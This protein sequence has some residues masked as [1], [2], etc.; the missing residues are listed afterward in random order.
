MGRAGHRLHLPSLAKVREAAPGLL[1]PAPIVAFDPFRPPVAAEGVVTV[2]SLEAAARRHPPARTVVHL[3]TPPHVRAAML[4]RLAG[5][6]YRT[7]IVEKP[8]AVDLIGLAA[9]ARI[10]RR[11]NL[12]L[13]VATHWLDSALTRRLRTAVTG[14]RHGNLRSIRVVQNKPRFAL[15]A[16]ARTHPTAF[17][18]EVPHALA[19]ALD[20][21][22]NARIADASSDDL[23]IGDRTIPR[24]GR[25]RLHLTHR[26]GV[27]T[28]IDSDLT[29]PVRER[30]IT[31]DFDDGLLIGHYPC[32]D[33][34]HT[35]Q[36]RAV[37]P[38]GETSWTVFDDDALP[39]FLHKT[40]ERY[41]APAP[42]PNDTLSLQ[43]DV[44]RLLTE[45]KRLCAGVPEVRGVG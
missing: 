27:R 29:S 39:A 20:L 26:S 2:G 1:A 38:G 11:W 18:V 8:L 4:D 21:A 45:A 15:G 35:A 28:E 44:V 42:A 32:S 14:G 41:A 13:T 12:H 30:R 9:V 10:R 19:V 7:I 24:L 37:R 36:L 33:A 5:L 16:G 40:Y 6:G 34:D 22:G 31:L 25:A 3:C 17:D 43:V 23:V